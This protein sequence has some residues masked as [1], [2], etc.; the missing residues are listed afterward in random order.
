MSAESMDQ[1]YSQSPKEEIAITLRVRPE[2]LLKVDRF[3]EEFGLRSR[4]DVVSR[5]L[6]ELLT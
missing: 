3:R 6:D 4:E 2:T 1:S 5:L